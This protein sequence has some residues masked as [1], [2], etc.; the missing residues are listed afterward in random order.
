MELTAQ[1]RGVDI[2]SVGDFGE[3]VACAV[4]AG[5]FAHV[6]VGHLATVSSALDA[7]RCQVGGDGPSMNAERSG[8]IG[9]CPPCVV[10]GDE[11]VDFEIGQAMLHWSSGWV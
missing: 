11:L 2:E 4:A 8:E 6:V 7:P 10:L 1:G 9:E 5:D 3:G